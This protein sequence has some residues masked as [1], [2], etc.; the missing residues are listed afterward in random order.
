ML[1]N[2][3]QEDVLLDLSRG[4]PAYGFLGPYFSYLLPFFKERALAL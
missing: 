4:W 1:E 2:G 3:S